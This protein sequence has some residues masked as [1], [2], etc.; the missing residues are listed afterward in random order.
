MRRFS[1]CALPALF[2]L[3]LTAATVATTGCDAVSASEPDAPEVQIVDFSSFEPESIRKDSFYV[4]SAR[5]DGDLLHL[6]VSYEG[7]CEGQEHSFTLYGTGPV[8]ETNPWSVYAWL[9]H[10]A[11]AATCEP[12]KTVQEKLVFD[13]SAY[14]NKGY[15]AVRLILRPY[16]GK[17]GSHVVTYGR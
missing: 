14:K 11:G 13:L 9:S 8:L 15:E 12:Q 17:N 16:R 10:E 6:D 4:D 3:T 5:V 7:G 1:T 2:A